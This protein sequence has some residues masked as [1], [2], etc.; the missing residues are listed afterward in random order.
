MFITL[1]IDTSLKKKKSVRMK[2]RK[3][4]PAKGWRQP[5]FTKKRSLWQRMKSWRRELR[6][7]NYQLDGQPM[8]F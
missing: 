8:M 4:N 1:T 2:R 7:G 6:G 3:F 5:V